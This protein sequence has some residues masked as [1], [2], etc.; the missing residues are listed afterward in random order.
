[1][2]EEGTVTKVIGNKAWV[3]AERCT[4]CES[5]ESKSM[6]H[7]FGGSSKNVEVETIN[8]ANAKVG[9]V[10]N[11][12]IK[13]STVMKAA[14]MVYVIPI[15]MLFV[16][17]FLGRWF[18]GRYGYDIDLTSLLTGALAFAITFLV[19]KVISKRISAKG[20]FIPVITKIKG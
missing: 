2:N 1:M 7:P 4:A 18:A 5:C 19:L 20:D 12:S 3:L 10:V 14:F 13:S 8:A 15:F 16:G 6:C 17:V 11:I 9:N